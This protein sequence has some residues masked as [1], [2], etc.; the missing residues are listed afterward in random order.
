[1]FKDCSFYSSSCKLKSTWKGVE[2]GM[3]S[4]PTHSR[5][6]EVGTAPSLMERKTLQEAAPVGTERFPGC[7]EIQTFGKAKIYPKEEA[8][9]ILPDT[10]WLER[11]SEPSWCPSFHRN[12]SMQ[13]PDFSEMKPL[14]KAGQPHLSRCSSP[15]EPP[16][17]TFQTPAAHP[18]FHPCS[19]Q[20]LSP[21]D[22]IPSL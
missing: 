12:L 14:R 10:P 5:P 4:D 13:N 3:A 15:R 20:D 1:M 2:G 19:I 18:L 21:G 9:Q 11:P 22:G 16:G 6:L 8:T 7:Q 17:R